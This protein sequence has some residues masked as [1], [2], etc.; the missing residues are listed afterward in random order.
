[1]APSYFSLYFMNKCN[2]YIYFMISFCSPELFY[3]LCF[4][5]SILPIY[6][7]IIIVFVHLFL[8]FFFFFYIHCCVYE[9][10]IEGPILNLLDLSWSSCLQLI[11]LTFPLTSLGTSYERVKSISLCVKE[12][13]PD[14]LLCRFLKIG[15]FKISYAETILVN[16]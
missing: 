16:M 3:F 6:L 5:Q 12:K 4:C 14:A 13:K 8:S 15:P 1:M 2:R 10:W 9:Q 7:S 11:F